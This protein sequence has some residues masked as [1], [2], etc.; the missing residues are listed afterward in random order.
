MA[1]GITF[2]ARL[3]TRDA[4]RALRQIRNLGEDPSPLLEEWG[5]ILEAS[6]RAR[7]DS[8]RGPGGVPWPISKRAKMQ[9]GKTLVDKGNLERSIRYE[10][11]G[12][13]ALLVG[14]DGASESAKHAASHQFGVNKPV[15]V[16]GHFR[17]INSAFGVPLKKP[18]RQ[19]VRSHGR[20]MNIPRR[21]FLGVDN[22]DRRDL[23]E[24]S[25][26]YIRDLLK[27]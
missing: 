24:A 22:N 21:E 26:S 1:L 25:R 4:Y 12:T 3:I 14:V 15:F 27:R 23:T 13:H 20:K 8:G 9:G 16:A 18:T 6:T 10:V 11:R 19:R 5:G 17:V 7:F 2:R